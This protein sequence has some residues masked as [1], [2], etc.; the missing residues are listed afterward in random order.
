MFC[1]VS[2]KNVMAVHDCK[3]VYHVPLLLVDQG[4]L[5]ILT[6]RLKITP[7]YSSPQTSSPLFLKWKDLTDRYD[8]LN[9][10]DSIEIAL[11]GKY[12]DL[13][14]SYISVVKA[15]HHAS[16]ACAVKPVIE[17]IEAS[18]LEADMKHTAP[19]QYHESWRRLCK[20][21]AILVPGGFGGRG[22]EGKV[23]AARW[24]REH[25]VP[26]LGICLGMQLAV[27]EFARNVCGLKGTFSLK[28]HFLYWNLLTLKP[29]LLQTPIL[30]NLKKTLSTPSLCSCLRSR[31]R[32]W[33]ERCV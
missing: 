6:T 29:P 10:R 14:D 21:R 20:A 3:S 1:H 27:V 13:K 8:R 30:P 32:T 5:E 15:L 25:E 18:D 16:L 7:T 26:Y 12:T 23:L 19:L 33:A 31:R 9:E 17:W 4:I 28:P 22:T 2:A 24:A 11:V